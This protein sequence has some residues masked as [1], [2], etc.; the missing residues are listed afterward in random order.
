[1]QDLAFEKVASLAV[2]RLLLLRIVAAVAGFGMLHA[3]ALAQSESVPASQLES[4]RRLMPSI[5]SRAK[6]AAMMRR[7]TSLEL[8]KE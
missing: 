7:L 5:P 4:R 3:S 2:R 6:L 1:M 8:P